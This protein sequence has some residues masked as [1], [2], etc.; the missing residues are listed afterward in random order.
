MLTAVDDR[1]AEQYG[2]I[3]DR[4]STFGAVSGI[5]D[6]RQT[7]A[8]GRQPGNA[9]NPTGRPANADTT[10][11]GV[12]AAFSREGLQRAALLKNG[13]PEQLSEEEQRQVQELKRRDREVRQHEQAHLAAAGAYAQGGAHYEYT[14]GPDGQQY[15]TGGEVSLSVGPGRTPQETIAKA[16]QVRRAALAPAN[17]SGQDRQVAAEASQMEQSAR[18]EMAK[19]AQAEAQDAGATQTGATSATPGTTTPTPQ[20]NEGAAQAAIQLIQ[21]QT[22]PGTATPGGPAVSANRHA[23]DLLV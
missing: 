5:Q 22:Q 8:G 17:P 12:Q 18:L 11:G 21:T 15:A 16:E 7:T 1:T 2:S 10:V 23:L 14:R 9:V 19:E 6:P 13:Q 20:G 3:L 4:R